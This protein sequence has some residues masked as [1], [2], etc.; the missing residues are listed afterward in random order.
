MSRVFQAKVRIDARRV[1]TCMLDAQLVKQPRQVLFVVQ[2]RGLLCYPGSIDSLVRLVHNTWVIW[3]Q[4]HDIFFCTVPL[5]SVVTAVDEISGSWR[6]AIL[7]VSPKRKVCWYC[8]AG[9]CFW[10]W[11]DTML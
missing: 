10:S 8:D 4:E 1:K 2:L 3:I 5:Q 7:S 9:N 11:T 6:E